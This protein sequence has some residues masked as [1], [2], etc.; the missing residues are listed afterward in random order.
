MNESAHD[1]S[2]DHATISGA[3]QLWADAFNSGNAAAIAAMM[4][5]DA[6]LFP[7]N[8]DM[9]EG[10]D[11]IQ[12]FWQAFID[13]GVKGALEMTELEVGGEMAYKTGTFQILDLEGNEIDHGKFLEVWRRIDGTWQFHRDMWNSS[14]PAPEEG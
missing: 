14:V 10:H 11:A 4:S 3:T 6:R 9:V 13:L 2:A 12:A 5:A 7:P 1:T 8:G